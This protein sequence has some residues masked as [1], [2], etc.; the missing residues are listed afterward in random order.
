MSGKPAFTALLL[1]LVVSSQAIDPKEPPLETLTVAEVS[2]RAVSLGDVSFRLKFLYRQEI[3][4]ID[5]D[6]YWV[7]VFDLDYSSV[8]VQF[9]KEALNYFKKITTED[10]AYKKFRGSQY[11]GTSSAG[12]SFVY[13]K[14]RAVT[15]ENKPSWFYQYSMNSKMTPLLILDAVGKSASKNISGETKYKW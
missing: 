7:R 8:V 15:P 12:A 14:G 10:E 11:Y 3:N 6:H 2:E 9:P 4:P 13:V 5:A 1:S